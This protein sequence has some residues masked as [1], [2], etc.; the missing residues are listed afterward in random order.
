MKKFLIFTLTEFGTMMLMI[1]LLAPLANELSQVYGYEFSFRDSLVISKNIV[2]STIF[3]FFGLK[4][5]NRVFNYFV[6]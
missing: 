6:K 2:C 3:I 5:I 4:V 1:L